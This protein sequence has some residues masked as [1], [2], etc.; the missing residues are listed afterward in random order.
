MYSEIITLVLFQVSKVLEEFDIEERPMF[1]WEAQCPNVT[2][3]QHTV[4]G[5]RAEKKVNYTHIVTGWN[6]FSLHSLKH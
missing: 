6:K 1:E 3:R 5:L 2:V 4:G